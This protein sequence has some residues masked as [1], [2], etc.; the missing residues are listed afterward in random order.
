MELALVQIQ[1]YLDTLLAESPEF[2]CIN[3]KIKPTNNIKI[4][5]DGDMG[6]TIEKCVQI[7]RKLYK[8]IE[9]NGFYEEGDFSLEISSP[10]V[11]EPL[12]LIRQ[13]QK[14]IGRFLEITFE[15]DTVKEGQLM[16]VLENEIIIE[17]TEGKGKK[18]IIEQV[19]INIAT[20]NNLTTIVQV[21]F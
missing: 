12:K 13:Y 19:T 15:N 10:G 2:F 4:F 3:L 1:N 16:E 11:D 6:I 9:E 21:R 14:N 20:I 8:F 17:T 7:N 18:A 5:L